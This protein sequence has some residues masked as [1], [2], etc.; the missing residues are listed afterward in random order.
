MLLSTNFSVI[1]EN[2]G[3]WKPIFSHILRLFDKLY[4]F[5]CLILKRTDVSTKVI[6]Q[7]KELKRWLFVCN[8]LYGK[9]WG[10]FWLSTETSFVMEVSNDELWKESNRFYKIVLGLFA[11]ALCLRDRELFICGLLKLKQIFSRLLL[12]LVF[13]KMTTLFGKLEYSFSARHTV[14]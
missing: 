7:K 5:Y 2:K 4:K 8:K 3:Q 6:N 12:I 1:R 13:E 11:I 9:S 10:G 14:S